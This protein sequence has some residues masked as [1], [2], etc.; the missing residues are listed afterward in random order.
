[1]RAEKLTKYL[2]KR[3][4]QGTVI[5]CFKIL[6]DEVILN[7]S[8]STLLKSE[9]NYRFDS[10]HK[11]YGVGT[12]R[13]DYLL[14]QSSK[15]ESN[16]IGVQAD[17][18]TFFINPDFISGLSTEELEGISHEIEKHFADILDKRKVF[19]DEIR[20]YLDSSLKV[21]RTFLI[22]MLTKRETD[23]IY[24]NDGGVDFA[25]Q[26]AIYQ[27]TTSLTSKK[28]EEDLQKAPLKKRI[29]V[30]KKIT[31]SFDDNQFND[32]L[33]LDYISIDDLIEHLDYLFKKKPEQNSRSIIHELIFEFEREYHL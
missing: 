27:V 2:T 30:Y 22:E 25:S 18:T 32:D 7:G 11:N 31:P 21:R 15:G 8:A 16:A 29:F 23:K 17:N 9:I 33:I 13:S 28:F 19:F 1:M 3:K 12:F 4:N 5:L 26:Q 10:V 24:S 20:S 6:L 14:R